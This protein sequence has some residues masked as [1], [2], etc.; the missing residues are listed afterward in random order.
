MELSNFAGLTHEHEGVSFPVYHAGEGPPVL[1]MHELPGMVPECLAFAERLVEAG[2]SVY[3][4][5][6]FGRPGQKPELIRPFLQLCISR[7]F[8]LLARHRTSP[9]VQWLRSLCR[10]VH[11]E[12]GGKGMG[13]IGMCLTGGFAIPLMVE[14]AVVAPVV[15]QP[16]MPIGLTASHRRSLNASEEDLR[17]A[18]TRTEEGVT[19]RSYRFDRDRLAPKA[20]MQAYQDFFGEAFQYHELDS[21]RQ[22]AY[23][24]GCHSVFTLDYVDEPGHPTREAF[25]DLVGFFTKALK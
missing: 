15:S 6:F 1:I 24:K 19:I 20:R 5:L 25:E 13:A 21:S 17:V 4:P 23:Q 9:V 16:A 18:R 2:F 12:V 7:E 14:P 3:L 22:K 11:A 10:K 8:L